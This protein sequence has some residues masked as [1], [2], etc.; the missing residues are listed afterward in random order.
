MHRVDV[1]VLRVV[2]EGCACVDQVDTKGVGADCGPRFFS[3]PLLREKGTHM[4]VRTRVHCALTPWRRCVVD[5]L[6]P[7]RLAEERLR[8]PAATSGRRRIAPA[9]APGEQR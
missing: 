4:R 3:F 7:A 9:S 6:S 5:A 1:E 2:H 8:V